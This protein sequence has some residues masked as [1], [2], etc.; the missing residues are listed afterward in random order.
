MEMVVGRHEGQSMS[1]DAGAFLDMR[2]YTLMTF[3][4]TAILVRSSG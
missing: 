3:D 1:G 2:G 4:H